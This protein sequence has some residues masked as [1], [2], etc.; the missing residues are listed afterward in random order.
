MKGDGKTSITIRVDLPVYNRVASLALHEN[1]SVTNFL[2]TLV[3]DELR[4]LKGVITS[5]D[6]TKRSELLA[7]LDDEN[8]PL[9]MAKNLRDELHRMIDQALKIQTE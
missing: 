2:E 7:T 3:L 8:F 9:G 6:I 1:R 4:K 5:G